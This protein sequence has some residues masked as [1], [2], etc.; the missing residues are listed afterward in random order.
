[1][2]PLLLKQNELDSIHILASAI[3]D[4]D[5]S[6]D[7]INEH[8]LNGKTTI[9]QNITILND[10]FSYLGYSDLKLTIANGKVSLNN[11]SHKAH[12]NLLLFV[13]E[14]FVLDSPT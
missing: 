14:Y 2:L 5:S 8:I 7:Y 13:A 4:L 6:V 3:Y 9:K 12:S 10:T 11:F 1:M